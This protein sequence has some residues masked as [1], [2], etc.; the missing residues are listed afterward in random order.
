MTEHA[1]R[2]M[3]IVVLSTSIHACPDADASMCMLVT[4]RHD[5]EV[6]IKITCLT[7]PL[8]GIAWHAAGA[9]LNK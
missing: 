9:L 7:L 3:Q 6:S 8:P 2:I 5:G 4:V 1:I